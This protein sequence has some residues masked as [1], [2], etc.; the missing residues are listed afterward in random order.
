MNILLV[1][2]DPSLAYVLQ[3][4]LERAG[5]RVLGPAASCKEARVLL[6]VEDS[7]E[8]I[9]LIDVQLADARPGTEL[10]AELQCERNIPC[11]FTTGE[12]DTAYLN[13]ETG[14]GVLAKPYELTS[15]T[16]AVDAII[17]KMA[18][19]EPFHIPPGLV[20]FDSWS[21]YT[22]SLVR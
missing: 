7:D 3:H 20:L 17:C 5:H 19:R 2:D 15:V 16:A 13:A 14:V 9:A 11:L 8:M 12:V 21:S 18:G 22:P 10:A 1:E 4:S 6:S